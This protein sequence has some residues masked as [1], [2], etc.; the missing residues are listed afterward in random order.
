[1]VILS[2]QTLR[3]ILHQNYILFL[4]VV[5]FFTTINNYNV[6][7]AQSAVEAVAPFLSLF[8]NG[9]LARMTQIATDLAVQTMNSNREM[10][11]KEGRPESRNIDLS[12]SPSQMLG[13]SLVNANNGVRESIEKTLQ[14]NGNNNNFFKPLSPLPT[15]LPLQQLPPNPL[16]VK[17]IK[18]KPKKDGKS[19]KIRV[20]KNNNEKLNVKKL[21]A[22][23]YI[24][25]GE[26]ANISNDG[27]SNITPETRAAKIALLKEIEKEGIKIPDNIKKE[28]IGFDNIKSFEEEASI[29]NSKPILRESGSKEIDVKPLDLENFVPKRPDAFVGNVENVRQP[30]SQNSNINPL[31]RLAETFLGR[32]NNNGGNYARGTTTY[33]ERGEYLGGSKG[34]IPSIRETV[35][36]ANSNF[37][38]PKGAGCL[39][40]IGEFMQV[41]YGNCV[42]YADERTFDAW[43]NEIKNVITGSGIDLFKASI[44][45]C[46]MQAEKELCGQIRKAISECDILGTIQV[47]SQIQRSFD[48]CEQVTGIVDQNPLKMMQGISTLVNGEVAQGFINNFLG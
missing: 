16:L 38:I 42:K 8:S 35:P 7:Q 3:K 32:G 19:R 40:F 15:P 11:N 36:G 30:S 43:G 24:D 27:K 44:E 37:G 46:K 22:Q 33:Q 5:V 48:R 10:M 13:Q 6:V 29:T 4:F 45:T 1:M 9:G 34:P 18:K 47:G 23:K 21:S 28:V 20:I 17:K 2:T 31:L 25:S 14:K 39:P 12:M 41:A 26:N